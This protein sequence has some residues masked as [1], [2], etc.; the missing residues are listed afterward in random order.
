MDGSTGNKS[1][2]GWHSY[3]LRRITSCKDY[4]SS[5]H[6]LDNELSA[7][8]FADDDNNADCVFQ[9]EMTNALAT[10]RVDYDQV[11]IKKIE[12]SNNPMLMKRKKK[13]ALAMN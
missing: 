4:H 10:M 12:D 1:D 5:T 7:S 13:K 6:R 8:L 3:P 11:Q 9:E 2:L